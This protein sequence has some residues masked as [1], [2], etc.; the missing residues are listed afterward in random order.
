MQIYNS[1]EPVLDAYSL[2]LSSI[3]FKQKNQILGEA[4]EE[5][6]SLKPNSCWFLFV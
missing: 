1:K 3:I 4:P 6:K 5:K 2:K